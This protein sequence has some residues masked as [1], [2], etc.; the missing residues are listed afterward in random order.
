MRAPR[1]VRP[2]TR[3]MTLIELLSAMMIGSLLM[4]TIAYSFSLQHRFYSR[5]LDYTEALQNARVSLDVMRDYIRRAGFG[6]R[7]HPNAT[8]VSGVGMCFDDSGADNFAQCN[9]V[10][11]GSDRLRIYMGLP[12]GHLRT[13]SGDAAAINQI[14]IAN[15]AGWA[16]DPYE[17][18]PELGQPS[19]IVIQGKVAMISGLCHSSTP[20]EV[21]G[22]DVVKIIGDAP[23]GAGHHHNY[24]YAQVTSGSTS[25]LGCPNGYTDFSFG[26]AQVVDFYIDKSVPD[27]PTLKMRITGTTG[28][29]PGG[30][31][32]DALTVAEDIETLQV[33]YGLDTSGNT[34]IADR[35]CN[36]P[37]DIGASCATGL[38]RSQNLAR[39]VA[40][41][42]AIV[43]R[44][45]Q[46]RRHISGFP[47][48]VLDYSPPAE[49]DGYNR[50]V[51][52]ATI[53]M[54]NNR[55]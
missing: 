31:W 9:N 53:A 32:E 2:S 27:H 19:P 34:G 36:D 25:F 15:I 6:F 55:L 24:S 40:T 11:D 35:W 7:S 29:D 20:A 47:L 3:G 39:I 52:R 48:G 42:V 10:D 43:A 16:R 4:S 46:K 5:K 8:G 37:A 14:P 38:S 45:R 50:F 18:R 28:D 12:D 21:S 1:R 44:T 23:G 26:P 49:I 30:A 22:T 51:F 13:Q 41:R 54:R 33:Q 17:A